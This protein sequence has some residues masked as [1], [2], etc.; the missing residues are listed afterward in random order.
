MDKPRGKTRALI[1]TP[2]RELAAQIEEHLN[3]LAVP[4][5]SLARPSSAASEWDRRARV[6][7]FGVDVLVA[8]PGR[9][10]DTSRF[11]YAKLESLESSSRRG[12]SDARYGLPPRHPARPKHFRPAADRLFFSAT[13][14]RRS[15]N[16]A[17]QMLINPATVT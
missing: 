9:L 17:N 11:P 6:P 7:R 10:L 14:P 4:R 8:T 16:L 15:R 5:R 13:I 2:K 1:L 12:R 3:Q